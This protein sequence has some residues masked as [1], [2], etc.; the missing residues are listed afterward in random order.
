MRMALADIVV[1]GVT[2]LTDPK[3]RANQ[4][5]SR[6]TAYY[7]NQKYDLPDEAYRLIEINL[8]TLKSN[9]EILKEH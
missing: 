5:S 7:M 9:S 2:R 6:S 1:L 4:Q 3:A 8:E